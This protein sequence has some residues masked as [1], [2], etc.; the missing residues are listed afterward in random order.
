MAAP[1]ITLIT[2]FGSEDAYV[3][4]MKGQMLSICPTIHFVDV[5]HAIASQDIDQAALVL[6]QSAPH[7][8]ANTIHLVIVDPGVGTQRRMLAVQMDLACETG[9]R[10]RRQ[11][12]VL[13]DNGLISPLVD[14]GDNVAINILDNPRFW[15]RSVSSTFHGRDIMGP[16]AAHWAGGCSREEF[17]PHIEQIERLAWPQPT[18]EPSEARG[19]V[20]WLDHFGNAITNVPGSWFSSVS[21]RALTVTLGSR[22]MPIE[23]TTTYGERAD[24]TV[25]LLIGSHEL[26]ELAVVRGNAAVQLAVARGDEVT[27]RAG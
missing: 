7:F 10:S 26:V 15:R 5:T 12:F 8:P 18:L 20:I 9:G 21:G 16:V 14:V 11:R 19:K 25:V 3:A 22:V 27:I 13:P 4:Q 6:R 23:Q 24:K 1:L 17:G 2:D